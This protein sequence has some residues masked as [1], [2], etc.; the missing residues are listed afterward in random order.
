MSE[1]KAVNTR[2]PGALPVAN[3]ALD[4]VVIEKD[5]DKEISERTQSHVDSI[6][7][8][9]RLDTC[10]EASSEMDL[11]LMILDGWVSQT[12]DKDY[13]RTATVESRCACLL[14][15]LSAFDATAVCV[16]YD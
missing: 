8:R 2:E 7:R 5:I 1:P 10:A 3:G 11:Y 9:L 4:E 12:S 16:R 13:D 6:V 15:T 14:R